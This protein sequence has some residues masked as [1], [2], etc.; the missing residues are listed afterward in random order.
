MRHI[1]AVILSTGYFTVLP[2]VIYCA[3]VYSN[4]ATGADFGGLLVYLIIPILGGVIGFCLSAVFFLPLCLLAEK[5]HFS[6]WLLALGTLT[7]G[8]LMI[9][10]ATWLQ[11]GIPLSDPVSLSRFM[12]GLLLGLYGLI[13][14]SVY[15]TC[16]AIFRRLDSWSQSRRETGPDNQPTDTNPAPQTP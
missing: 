3:T 2:L 1:L 16:I 4:A 15:F 13:G 12:P 6:R 7:L 10:V 14:F 9:A 8:T 11:S 5:F